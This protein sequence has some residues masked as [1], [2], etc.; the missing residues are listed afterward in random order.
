MDHVW[1]VALDGSAFGLSSCER[2]GG[3]EFVDSVWRFAL[4]DSGHGLCSR[5]GVVALRSLPDDCG[6]LLSMVPRSGSLMVPG[7][8]FALALAWILQ[9]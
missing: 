6:A 5:F 7:V 3:G 2:C 9:L 8:G 4:D 1:R